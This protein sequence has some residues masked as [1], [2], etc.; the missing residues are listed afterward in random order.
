MHKVSPKCNE[1]KSENAGYIRR[2]AVSSAII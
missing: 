1:N 2:C